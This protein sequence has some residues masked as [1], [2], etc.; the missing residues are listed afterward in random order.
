MKRAREQLGAD[1]GHEALRRDIDIFIRQETQHYKQ[2]QLFN[3]TLYE[4]GYDRL[5]E[6][7]REL[8]RDYEGFL[9]NR[10]LKFNCVY[11][12]G[13]E[14]LGPPNAYAYIEREFGDLLQGPTRKP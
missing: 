3:K 13:F 6:F 5:P 4:A 12:E 14:T 8:A 1:A 7:E 10:S 9:R 2:H 11:C